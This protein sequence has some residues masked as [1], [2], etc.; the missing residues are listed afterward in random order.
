M[1]DIPSR[2]FAV[3]Q[4]I[5]NVRSSTRPMSVLPQVAADIDEAKSTII[6]TC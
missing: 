3:W 6:A 2:F 5:F 1:G 4:P